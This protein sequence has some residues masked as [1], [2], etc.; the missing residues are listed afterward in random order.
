MIESSSA[1][2]GFDWLAEW[3]MSSAVPTI[4]D[5]KLRFGVFMVGFDNHR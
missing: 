4:C 5:S 3:L 2:S 1:D